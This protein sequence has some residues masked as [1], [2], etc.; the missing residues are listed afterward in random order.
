M[1]V[2]GSRLDLIRKAVRRRMIMQDSQWLS[3]SPFIKLGDPSSSGSWTV[4]DILPPSGLQCIIKVPE[5]LNTLSL[6]VSSESDAK[7]VWNTL[8]ENNNRLKF[9][10]L[11]QSG[12]S[13]ISYIMGS[14]PESGKEPTLSPEALEFLYHYLPNITADNLVIHDD[15][16]KLSRKKARRLREQL[17]SGSQDTSQPDL[18]VESSGSAPAFCSEGFITYNYTLNGSGSGFARPQ[19]EETKHVPVYD[20]TAI[21]GSKVSSTAINWLLSNTGSSNSRYIGVVALPCTVDLAAQLDRLAVF[22]GK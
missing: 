9:N 15:G 8:A 12:A 19:G 4:S 2:G 22:V 11:D 7:L 1:S 10:V 3:Y 20:A 6:S 18:S 5:P 16:G 14:A 13:W 17:A 21:F